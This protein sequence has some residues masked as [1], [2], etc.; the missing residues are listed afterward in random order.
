MEGINMRRHDRVVSVFF[1]LLFFSCLGA[2]A[3]A[4]PV[5]HMEMVY[6]ENRDGTFTYYFKLTNDGPPLFTDPSTPPDHTLQAFNGT[7][8]DAGGKSLSEDQ[9]LV[10]FGIDLL[11]DDLVITRIRNGSTVFDGAVARGFHDTDGDGTRN[12][13]VAW[14][15]P[16]TFRQNQTVEPGETV[17]IFSFTLNR[18]VEA[19]EIFMGGTDDIETYMAFPAAGVDDYGVYDAALQRYFATFLTV[20][21]RPVEVR[22][23]GLREFFRDVNDP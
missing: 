14:H 2:V 19:F 12:Q 17:G 4:S 13:T 11:A 15:L 7:T 9:Y 8:L 22:Q 23:R 3:W 10:D 6:I 1:L 20:P 21:L 16:D 18:E 5:G